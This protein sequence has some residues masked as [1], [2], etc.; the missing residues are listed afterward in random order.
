MR[1]RLDVSYKGTNYFGWQK[2]PDQPSIQQTL[3]K[4]LSK[5]FNYK[6]RDSSDGV[7]DNTDDLPPKLE[8]DKQYV[9]RFKTQGSGRTDAGTHAYQ[10]VVDFEILQSIDNFD[11]VRGLNRYLPQDIR[12]MN[13]FI[14]PDDFNSLKSS[15]S[16]TYVYKI[17]NQEVPCPIKAD[18]TYWVRNPLD[19]D[20][21]NKITTPLIGVHDFE[22]FQTS[23]TPLLTTVREI[24]SAKWTKQP[25]NE[26]W[27]TISGNGFLKQMVRNIVGTLL[28]GHWKQAH[29]AESIAKI[30]SSKSRPQAGST[31]PAHGLYLYEVKYPEDLDKKCL[32]S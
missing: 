22:A 13:A 3:E 21:L 31:A 15:I 12:V 23:G 24:Y 2:Q 18:L 10:Q 19:L 9:Q 20:Y 14:V 25:D 28:D 26:V 27:F 8:V 7:V 30:L 5:L 11:V 4:A 32:K 29:T 1:I 16:K 6:A 17:N